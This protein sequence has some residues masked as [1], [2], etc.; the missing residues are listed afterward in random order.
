MANIKPNL[1]LITT[2]QQR[3]DSLSRLG[4]PGYR[5]PVLDRLADEGTCFDWAYCPAP[6]CTPARVSILTG[7]YP[8]RHGA[9][10]IGMEPVPAL[11]GPT[12][13]PLLAAGGYHSAMIGKTHFVARC[14]EHQHVAGAVDPSPDKPDPDGDF[15]RKFDGPYVGF[16]YVRHC[17]SHTCDRPPN[18]H[19]RAWLDGKGVNLDHLHV[20]I[21]D[22][23][24]IYP[25]PEAGRWDI[26]ES[27]TQTAWITEES[28]AYI[29]RRQRTGRPWFCWASYQDP[30]PPFVCPEPYYSGV[31]MNGVDL[32]G[33]RPGEMDDKPPLYK[34]FIE[35][36]Y[37]TEEPDINF[38]D[39]INVPALYLYDAQKDLQK[40]IRA[41]IGMVNM[42]DV[43]VGRLLEALDRMGARENTLVI[44][45]TDHGE[46]LGRHGMWGKG[47]AAYDDHQRIPAVASWPAAQKGPVGGTKSMFNLVDILP[48][49]LE[50]AG[51]EIPP[52]VQGV[53]QLPVIC[54]QTEMLRDW[55]L[56]DFMAT[57]K[58]H[59]QTFIHDGWKLV[60]YRHSDYGELYNLGEDP[61]QYRN[62]F[63]RPDARE[64]RDRMMHRLVRAQMESAGKMPRRIAS[65]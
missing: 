51:L 61:D 43:Y 56:V 29:E 42:T 18:A 44:F 52:G 24:R 32:G 33:L 36:H 8:T 10:E 26:D 4:R 19:Y 39:G 6:M 1:L 46:M 37:W 5:T 22:G 58:L 57:V 15:W 49:F 2:D 11:S 41:Y 30:H 12:I 14:I 3:W 38:W 53:S 55:A 28:I 63:N 16:D 17:Q 40:A 31:D 45:T 47:V 59:Q 54:G 65:A 35:G 20:Q 27:L 25:I 64:I 23:K 50:A 13:A 62:L 9:Y 21:K 34:R 7:Q 48:T 60:V